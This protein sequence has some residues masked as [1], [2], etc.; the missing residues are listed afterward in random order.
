MKSKL[1]FLTKIYFFL[2]VV[3]TTNQITA[4][5]HK[6][7]ETTSSSILTSVS[8]DRN[9]L[10]ADFEL[11][12]SKTNVETTVKI[13]QYFI[14]KSVAFPEIFKKQLE[15]EGTKKSFQLI[16]H[17]R[18]G[19]LLIDGEWKNAEQIV[20]FLKP[21]IAFLTSHINIYGCE[22]AKGEKGLEAVAFIEKE[23]NISVSASSN[24]TG[25]NGDWILEI[26]QSYN[27]LTF[28][29]YEENLQSCPNLITNGTFTGN[30]NGWSVSQ[31]WTYFGNLASGTN[32]GTGNLSQTINFASAT[33]ETITLNFSLLL[34]NL[35]NVWNNNGSGTLVI[36][37][38]GITYV[39]FVNTP[40]IN[41][42]TGTMTLSNGATITPINSYT[43]NIWWFNKLYI[44][45]TS[46]FFTCKW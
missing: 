29:R 25:K 39:T 15:S 32:N 3:F 35:N 38:A 30:L 19:E 33:N 24:I 8:I 45:D 23:L 21:N 18:P 7:I 31:P 42:R 9:S 13:G 6:T 5:T 44:N 36:K 4:K 26:G 2:C 28:P 22:F 14:D 20:A 17:G 34:G 41:A 37:I 43:P 46:S 40:I 12:A 10:K 16:S 11:N 1:I 27:N